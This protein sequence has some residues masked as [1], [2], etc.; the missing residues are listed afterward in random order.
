MMTTSS[1]PRWKIALIGFG[2]IGRIHAAMIRRMADAELVA[3]CDPNPN[4]RAT[5]DTMGYEHVPLFD[6]IGQLIRRTEEANVA[7]VCTPSGCHMEP[8]IAAIQFGMNVIIE[9]PL[10]I[11]SRRIDA[12]LELAD[13]HGVRVAGIFQHRWDPVFAAIH[14]AAVQNRFGTVA[15]AGCS[16]PWFRNEEYY[17]SSS[18]RGTWKI[19]GGG[20]V[21]NQSIHAIDLLQWIAGPIVRV[22]AMMDRR[23]HREIETEDTLT[24]AVRFQNG[25]FGTIM[26]TTA[27][28]PG[29]PLRLEIGGSD[30]TAVAEG[31][32]KMFAFRQPLTTD[33]ELLT[34]LGTS[35]GSSGGGA[36][37]TDFSSELHLKNV[38]QIIADWN[39]GNDAV[40]SGREVRKAVDIICA[41]YE[42]ARN[43]APVDLPP[44]NRND[45]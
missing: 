21:M 17:R 22:T 5:L 37:P 12:V 9:K 40:T 25:A 24:C 41:M 4:G 35:E 39:L 29:K 28:F 2:A 16:V 13:R 18:W 31:G 36:A 3:V 45:R 15:F 14:E 7:F 23:L 30:G 42:S 38:E 1:Q 44:A 34:R 43:N 10:E 32:L 27:M 33:Q 8:A 11:D 26:G 6:N 20:A 19:D